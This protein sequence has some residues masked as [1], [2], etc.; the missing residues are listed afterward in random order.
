MKMANKC[1]KCNDMID[2]LPE[3]H[4]NV[5]CDDCFS[6]LVNRGDMLRAGIDKALDA[7][8][9]SNK[10]LRETIKQDNEF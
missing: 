3:T 6:A 7:Y 5:L 2:A 9:N 8:C 10:H 4:G 1:C